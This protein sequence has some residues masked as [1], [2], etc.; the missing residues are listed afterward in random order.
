MISLETGTHRHFL[1]SKDLV[2]GNFGVM[3][4]GNLVET[5]GT[6]HRRDESNRE[7]EP[8]SPASASRKNHHFHQDYFFAGGKSTVS[9]T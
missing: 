2:S 7:A 5:S 1:R 4:G 3:G 8:E 6:V 9:I